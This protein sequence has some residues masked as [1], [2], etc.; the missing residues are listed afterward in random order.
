[1]Y[2]ET[3]KESGEVTYGELKRLLKKSGSCFHH[4]GG[5]HE[6]WENPK[7]R[8]QYPVGRHDTKEVPKGTLES[9]KKSTGI[10]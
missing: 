10:K 9:I 4:H 8:E 1:M 5:R 7:T 3:K 2:I 6:M